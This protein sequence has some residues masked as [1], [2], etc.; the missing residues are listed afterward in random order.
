MREKK[1]GLNQIRRIV[2]IERKRVD[3]GDELTQLIFK[4]L[5]CF[6]GVKCTPC[7]MVMITTL[8]IL[9]PDTHIVFTTD[10]TLSGG[11]QIYIN[12]FYL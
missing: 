4:L 8:I 5:L 7:Q 2:K 6:L 11:L 1:T 3:L 12:S 9:I 10:Q